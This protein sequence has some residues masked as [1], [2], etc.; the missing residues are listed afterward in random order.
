MD[1][2][3][4]F[5]NFKIRVIHVYINKTYT[6]KTVNAYNTEATVKPVLLKLLKL[7]L[8]HSTRRHYAQ[9]PF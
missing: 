5:N 4:K 8:L 3:L 1:I 6:F 7:L 2:P 9:E